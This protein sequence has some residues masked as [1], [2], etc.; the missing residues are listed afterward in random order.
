MLYELI[1]RKIQEAEEVQSQRE[2]EEAWRQHEEEE[3]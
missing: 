1:W 2:V 3:M